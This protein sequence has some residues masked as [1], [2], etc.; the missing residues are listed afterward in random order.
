MVSTAALVIVL[1]S[2]SGIEGLITSLYSDYYQDIK[3]ESTN[4]KTFDRSFIPDEVFI[5][6]GLVNYSEVIED[7][8]MVKYD[9]NSIFTTVVGVEDPF[10]EMTNMSQHLD[11]G[12]PIL[13]DN[14]GPLALIGLEA[15]YALDAYIYT[16]AG[17]NENITLFAPNRNKKLRTNTMAMADAFT[18][19]RIDLVG[20]FAF[21]TSET[22]NLIIVPIEFASEILQYD[23]EVTS[24][25]IDFSDDVDLESKKAELQEIVGPSFKVKTGFEQN[26][27][28]YKTSKSEKW[29]TALLLAFIFF[30]STF[31]MI[32][33]ITMI[34]IE[35]R[36]NL[37]TLWAM[38]ARKNQLEKIFFYEGLLING[39]GI[40]LGLF[41]GYLI[42]FLQQTVGLI[43]MQDGIVDYYPVVFKLEDLLLILSITIFFGT[44]AA[45]LPGKF[46]IKR[47]IK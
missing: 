32:A 34:V 36:D 4:S 5:S 19:S 13:R 43:R 37:K 31:N 40:F 33:S 41:F 35:K 11:D 9:D 22:D 47:I 46:L 42:C 38:G 10:L 24:I 45:Y 27:L 3:I 7:I 25:Q 20:D 6:E 21:G 1:S 30:L 28:I 12:I 44:L 16:P 18:T 26:E 14:Y 29:F 17:S 23:N 15:E 8:V 2:F 39:I